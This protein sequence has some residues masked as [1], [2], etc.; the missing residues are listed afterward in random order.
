M[1]TIVWVKTDKNGKPKD[2]IG[3][4]L[5][6]MKEICLVGLIGNPPKDA[7]LKKAPDVILSEKRRHSQK[8]EEIYDIAEQLCPG[9]SYLELFG[10]HH[11][12]RPGWVTVGNQVDKA[13]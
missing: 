4:Y 7:A 6:H 12:L 1:D 9:G 10:R 2:G 5:R 11:N 13:L 8:P 3:F